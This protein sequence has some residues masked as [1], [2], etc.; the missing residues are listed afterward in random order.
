MSEPA[1]IVRT[2]RGV[3][4][5]LF[6]F[7]AATEL[8]QRLDA[9]IRCDTVETTDR[10]LRACLGDGWMAPSTGELWR[11][12]MLR[13]PPVLALASRGRRL[14]SRVGRQ[15]L[16]R[17][18]RR[19]QP[20]RHDHYDPEFERLVAPCYL[21][22]YFQ[23]QAYWSHAVGPLS[24]TVVGQL[25]VDAGSAGRPIVGVHVRRGDYLRQGWALDPNYYR[26]ALE[27]VTGE[28]EGAVLRVVGDDDAFVDAFRSQLAADGYATED[29]PGPPR[30]ADAALS[31]LMRLA[32]CDHLVL[33]NS[34][35]AWW[36]A[37]L[38]DHVHRGR[39]RLVTVPTRW[40]ESES[41]EVLC[42]PDWRP[43][44]GTADPHGGDEAE[45]PPYSDLVE[46]ADWWAATGHV[47][48]P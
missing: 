5:Q 30:H 21:M 3:G 11:C 29:D 31:D 25:G 45:P 2:H 41:S 46:F 20:A 22:G 36:G 33:S 34:S 38:G 9:P 40:I 18:P 10:L 24:A 23:H 14:L 7:A 15:A 43:V 26:R 17:P 27:L 8:A 32:E 6:Q 16:G 35:Y 42:R 37:A 12:G 44:A 39:T 4:N 1:V 13:H 47:S 19:F 28:V 48:P